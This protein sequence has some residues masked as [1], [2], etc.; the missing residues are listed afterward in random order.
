[1]TTPVVT[2][3]AEGMPTIIIRKGAVIT[4][5]RSTDADIQVVDPAVSRVHAKIKWKKDEPFPVIADNDSSLGLSVDDQYVEFSHLHHVHKI[6]IGDYRFTSAFHQDKSQIP[7]GLKKKGIKIFPPLQKVEKKKKKIEVSPTK[8]QKIGYFDDVMP[9][10]YK[11]A[12]E[13]AEEEANRA[14]ILSEIDTVDDVVLFEN[15]GK[16]PEKGR[17]RSNRQLHELLQFIEV[18]EQTGTLSLVS[19]HNAFITFAKGRMVRASCGR[20]NDMTAVQHIFMFPNASFTFSF[21]CEVGETQIDLTPTEYLKQMARHVT[22]AVARPSKRFTKLFE[23]DES[24]PQVN[25]HNSI[26]ILM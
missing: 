11:T 1:M 9:F 7:S 21:T 17:V 15:Y 18:K 10:T 23:E 20:L 22:K 26:N 25:D 19:E 13:R 6:L 14:A 3:S 24:N 4:I 16:S 8:I 12:E 5:G 2:L